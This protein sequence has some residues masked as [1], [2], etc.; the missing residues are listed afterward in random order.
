[1]ITKEKVILAYS[2]GL[3]SSVMIP[4]L[5]EHYDCEVVAFCCNLGQ[6]N[7]L[8]G[9]EDRALDAGASKVFFEDLRETFITQ[10]VY[11]ALKAGA[12]YESKYLLGTPLSRPLIAKRQIEIAKQE[13][14]TMVA[15][16]ATEKSSDP[17]RF[18]LTYRALEPN[19]RIIVPW[20]DPNWTLHSRQDC[21]AYAKEKNISIAQTEE[22]IYSEDRNI[23]HISHEGG[24]LKNTEDEPDSSIYSLSKTPKNAP[25]LEEYIE[26]GFLCGDPYSVNRIRLAPVQLLETLNQIGAR[27]AIGHVDMIE[28]KLTG[29]KARSVYETP[30]G[31]LLYAAH[32]ELERLI[33]DRD[34][35][36]YKDQLS[37]RY[38]ELVYDGHWFSPL[39]GAM[40]SFVKHTQRTVT[41]TVRLKLYKGN[42][43][44]VG[45]RSDTS[46]CRTDASEFSTQIP[47]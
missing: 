43:V 30:G 22:P 3:D 44:M 12:I 6:A 14:A 5:K 20:K 19:I 34:T 24:S 18:E 37:L 47:N 28:N 10:Y 42:I 9:L 21:I 46:L 36:H 2:G 23:W 7:D 8:N 31:T 35:Q 13:D 29:T 40:D 38:A 11:P 33:L 1:M 27:N 4:W 39:R 17:L 26:I 16:G 15:H 25:D 41:G 32:R 45:S